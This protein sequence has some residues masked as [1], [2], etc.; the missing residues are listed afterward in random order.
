MKRL[1]AVGAAA[2]LATACG[3]MMGG[4]ESGP[5]AVAQIG[6]TQSNEVRGTV[7]FTQKGDAVHV[8]TALN[9]LSPGSTHGIHVHEKGDCSAPDGMSAGGHYNPKG[10]AHGPQSGPHHEGDMPNI[11]A[12]SYG[13]TNASFD[14]A[15][16]KLEDLVGKAVVVHRDAD[17]YKSQPAGNSGP[18]IG[19]GVIKT[20]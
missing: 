13:G 19:C 16:V 12:G 6:P 1:L 20:A 3:S 17:D 15:G 2:C 5:R 14:I 18:R 11:M 7:T 10:S 4:G 8:E 9:G